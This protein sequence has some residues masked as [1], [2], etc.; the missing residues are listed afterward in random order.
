M[1]LTILALAYSLVAALVLNIWITSRW[2]V[3]FKVSLVALVAV[4]YVGTYFGIREIQGWPTTNPMP[5]SFELIWAKIDEPDKALGTEGQIY[6]W[7]RKLDVANRVSGEPRAYKLAYELSLAEEVERAINQTEDGVLL[8]GKMTRGILKAEE[9]NKEP[10]ER[11][12]DGEGDSDVTG[13]SDDQI[14]L[15]FTELPMNKL[16]AK[17]V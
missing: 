11:K 15:E 4:L 13:L 17:G 2:S 6:L 10:G 1:P 9:K 7:V 12:A 3:H 8:N 14:H 5:D 16:P